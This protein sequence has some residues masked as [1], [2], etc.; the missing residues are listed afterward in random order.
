[1]KLSLLTYTIGY[2]CIGNY[3]NL[4]HQT[5]CIAGFLMIFTGYL[6]LGDKFTAPAL[7]G[8][9]CVAVRRLDGKCIRGRNGAM[10]VEFENGERV[11]VLGRLLR[12][13][14]LPSIFEK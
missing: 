2:T 4:L 14:N 1:L 3:T 6:Y 8:K 7:K 5:N 11:I 10:L 9:L 13:R 12:K